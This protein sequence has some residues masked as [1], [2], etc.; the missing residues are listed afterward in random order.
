MIVQNLLV[1]SGLSVASMTSQESSLSHLAAKIRPSSFTAI[2]IRPFVWCLL[3]MRWNGQVP[4]R[5]VR[6]LNDMQTRLLGLIH[7]PVIRSSVGFKHD[8][9][10]DLAGT[11]FCCTPYISRVLSITLWFNPSLRCSSNTTRYT[12]P[13]ASYRYAGR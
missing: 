8:H 10:P 7:K 12:L 6:Y 3:H 11:C 13:R 1:N 5:S 4:V 2:C 9:Q